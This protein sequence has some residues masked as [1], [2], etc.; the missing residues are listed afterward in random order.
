[1]FVV[2]IHGVH[3]GRRLAMECLEMLVLRRNFLKISHYGSLEV[4]LVCGGFLEISRYE[5]LRIHTRDVLP[6]SRYARRDKRKFGKAC[7]LLPVAQIHWSQRLG[8]H[9]CAESLYTQMRQKTLH[10]VS[11]IETTCLVR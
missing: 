1:M 2:E 5:L 7:H 11:T 8:C 10:I 3:A 6:Q 9:Y 4:L